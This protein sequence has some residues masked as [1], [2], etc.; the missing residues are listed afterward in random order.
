MIDVISSCIDGSQSFDSLKTDYFIMLCHFDAM[1]CHWGALEPFSDLCFASVSRKY[2]CKGFLNK[3]Q[4]RKKVP[5]IQYIICTL[6][7]NN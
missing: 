7:S 6:F 3:C 2:L 5:W 4:E 1:D